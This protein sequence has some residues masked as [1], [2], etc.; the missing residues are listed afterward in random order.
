MRDD[1]PDYTY[2]CAAE[3]WGAL[4]NQEMA[5]KY[6]GLAVDNGWVEY[7][8]TSRVERFRFLHGAPEWEAVLT[9]IRQNAS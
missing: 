8:Y 2:N 3:A 7:D 9:R 6:L 1:H 5:L 4:G